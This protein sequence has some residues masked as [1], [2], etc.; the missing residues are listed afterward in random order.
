MRSTTCGPAAS[1]AQP[2][3]S[4]NRSSREGHPPAARA[5]CCDASDFLPGPG[6]NLGY[7][8]SLYARRRNSS[9]IRT[10]AGTPVA[11]ALIAALAAC[12]SNT[13]NARGRQTSNSVTR[14][15]RH[16]SLRDATIMTYDSGHG[17]QIGYTSAG[18]DAYLW[19]PGNAVVLPASARSA[20]TRSATATAPTYNS[21]TGQSGSGYECIPMARHDSIVV[22]TAKGDIFD[23]HGRRRPSFRLGRARTTLLAV[24]GR[25]GDC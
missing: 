12:S 20:A 9:P 17:T 5:P 22:N 25:C 23:L 7:W 18:G 1:R 11:L 13:G 2:F 8:Q 14:P 19:Y 10:R 4:H 21:V 3:S 16:G 15:A 6:F 24:L